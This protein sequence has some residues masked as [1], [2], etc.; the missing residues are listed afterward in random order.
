MLQ[1]AT[2]QPGSSA[3]HRADLA[4]SHVSKTATTTSASSTPVPPTRT[5]IVRGG[6]K[7]IHS[8]YPDG[9]ECIEDYDLKSEDLSMRKW[10]QKTVLGAWGAM[11]V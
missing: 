9:R 2:S 5:A 8:S 11:G 7:R 1:A 3:P 6:Y 4:C 10:R